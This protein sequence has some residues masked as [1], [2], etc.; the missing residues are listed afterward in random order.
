MPNDMIDHAD[1]ANR[2]KSPVLSADIVFRITSLSLT[3]LIDVCCSFVNPE[4]AF[5][6]YARA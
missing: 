6:G 1:K 4:A 3:L 5:T 2:E